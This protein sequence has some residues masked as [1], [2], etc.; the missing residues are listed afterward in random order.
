M[1]Y[2][3]KIKFSREFKNRFGVNFTKNRLGNLYYV[4]KNHPELLE[5]Y[6]DRYFGYFYCKNAI[7]FRKIL[8]RHTEGIES[9]L[10]GKK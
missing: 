10:K 8:L 5:Q 7:E 2:D 9:I 3:C 4:F 1:E 6:L